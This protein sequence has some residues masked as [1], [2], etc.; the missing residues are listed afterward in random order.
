MLI[1]SWSSALSARSCLLAH[2]TTGII[3]SDT[4]GCIFYQVLTRFMLAMIVI[5]IV[6]RLLMSLTFHV[7]LSRQLAST[8]PVRQSPAT[9]VVGHVK[10]ERHISSAEPIHPVVHRPSRP[11]YRFDTGDT[12]GMRGPL[13]LSL[14]TIML[15]TC[16]SEGEEA[17]RKTLDSLAS[18]HYSQDHKIFFIICDGMVT[19]S[20]NTKSTADICLELLSLHPNSV[21]PLPCPYRA[22]AE[23]ERQLNAAKVYA[24]YYKN[25]PALLVLKCG[26]EEEQHTFSRPGNRGKRDSQLLLMNFYQ[27]ILFHEHMSQLDY[28]IFWKMTMIIKGAVTPDQFELILMVDADTQV[29]PDALSHMVAAMTNDTRIMG[30][31][32][33]TKVANKS[34]SWVTAIQV[35]EYY[36]SHHYAK[37]FESVFGGVTCLPGCFS[38]YRIKAPKG[39]GWVPILASPDII[40]DYNHSVVN[41][42]HGKN[43][44]LLGEDRFLSTLMLRTFPRRQM[45][46]LPQAQC[47][48]TVPSTFPV[49]LSQRRRWI[50]STVHNL[51]ELVLVSDLCGIACLSMQF[52]VLL[53]LLASIVL[54]AAI[55]FSI[56]L[57]INIFI[58]RQAQ[59]QPLLLLLAIIGL[60]AI[61]VVFMT[62]KM[63]Y[64]GWMLIY[65]CSL[66]IWNFVLPIYAFWHFDDF[67]WGETRRVLEGETKRA[68]HDPVQNSI[69]VRVRF[70]SLGQWEKERWNILKM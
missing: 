29:L 13:P 11:S 8:A 50:N 42:L 18:T 38:M 59:L 17:L 31:C 9:T 52:V 64:I 12:S 69:S 48:T 61:L 14:Y 28:E 40:M 32:G 30:L 19:G 41:S 49:L 34:E 15:V 55:A 65:L 39:E 23:G 2:Y 5:L 16:Y 27:R 54:P 68:S 45:I 26:T 37:A 57:I 51:M 4:M 70:K 36:M 3:S 46:F 47:R 25:I 67:S 58:S 44:L 20:G 43:L 33:E 56:Y 53:D 60:P 66:P 7:Y 24:G 35:F 6:A 62:R 21:H 63:S 22:I 10:D 1:A